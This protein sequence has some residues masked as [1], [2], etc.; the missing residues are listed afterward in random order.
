MSR[1]RIKISTPCIATTRELALLL[2]WLLFLLRMLLS[3]SVPLV[4]GALGR[5]VEGGV[6][7]VAGWHGGSVGLGWWVG[8]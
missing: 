5:G 6:G 1:I 2:L 4:E 3:L 7:W 8:M